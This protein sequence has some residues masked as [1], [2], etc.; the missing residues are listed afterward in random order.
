VKITSIRLTNFRNWYNAHFEFSDRVLIY[1][2]N[3]LGKT[4]ILE[5]LYILATTRSFR[6]RD[7][8]I[9]TKGE[10][11]CRIE[12]KLEKERVLEVEAV[13]RQ[14]DLRVEKEFIINSKKR[15][16]ID[17]VGEF[18]AIVFSPEDISLVSGPPEDKRRYLSFTIGQNDREYLFELLNYKRILKQRN[19]LLKRADLGTI[20]EEI[21]IWD[22][23]LSE[24]G[25]KIIEKR[26]EFGDFVNK[27]LTKRYR[28]LSGDEKEIF[29]EYLPGLSDIDH[30]SSLTKNRDR[31]I[32]ERTTTVGPHRDSW[33]MIINGERASMVASRGEMR[34]IMLALKLCEKEWFYFKGQEMPVVLLDDVFSELDI[35]RR[36]LLVS[37]FS[38]CQ[39][40]MTTTDLDHLTPSLQANSQLINIEEV[41]AVING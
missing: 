21:D 32:R 1:G 30:Q 7:A 33:E 12:G 41:G 40:I 13:Y 23:H 10:G 31:D 28:S 29:F 34:T 18:S 15:S 14:Q 38:G 8:E 25:Q 17:F 37:G 39:L 36:E 2:P 16:S 9:I 24:Y 22:H 20:R 6:G 3:A 4:N 19:E 26:V 27:Y 5:S 35:K 11:F